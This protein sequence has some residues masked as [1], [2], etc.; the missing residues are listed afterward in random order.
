MTKFADFGIPAS[1]AFGFALRS[2]APAPSQC[3]LKAACV[4]AGAAIQAF[5]EGARRG[6]SF[7]RLWELSECERRAVTA[8]CAYR[9]ATP[10]DLAE[11]ALLL[12]K[13]A[14]AGNPANATLEN[15]ALS[16][17]AEAV[18]LARDIATSERR[19]N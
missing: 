4:A 1:A 11:K 13:V 3:T 15:L 10:A 19:R 8:A 5:D 9:A 12:D 7:I 2:E 14:N 17:A 18:A 6:D 16:L